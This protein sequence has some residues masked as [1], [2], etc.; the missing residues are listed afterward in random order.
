MPQTIENFLTDVNH[1]PERP[2][3]DIFRMIPV[4]S[5]AQGWYPPDE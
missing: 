4:F 2:W 3:S 1:Q 5:L